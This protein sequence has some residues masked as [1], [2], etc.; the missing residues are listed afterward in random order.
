MKQ[1]SNLAQIAPEDGMLHAHGHFE[2]SVNGGPWE[3]EPNLVVTEGLNYLLAS[4]LGGAAQKA[5]F[6]LAVFGGNVTPVASWT[7]ANFAANATEFTNYDE[8]TRVAWQDDAVAAGAI[9]N[10][11]NPAVFT[12]GAGGGTI[13]GAALVEASAKGATS[14]ILVAAARFAT[15]KVMSAGEELRVKY[16]IGASST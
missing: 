9:G 16:V 6:N 2:V 13:R 11:T 5:T 14:G 4:A 8:A 3:I 12:I 10:N 15:D 7:G 1:D